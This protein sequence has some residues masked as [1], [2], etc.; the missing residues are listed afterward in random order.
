MV[1][2]DGDGAR[3]ESQALV[4]LV[5]EDH[6]RVR[7]VFYSDVVARSGG[8]RILERRHRVGWSI[9]LGGSHA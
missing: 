4:H 3:V 8:R 5:Y 1:A 9:D 2:V 7:G 6:V